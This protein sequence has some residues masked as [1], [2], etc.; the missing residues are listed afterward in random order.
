MAAAFKYIGPKIKSLFPIVEIDGDEMARVIW[1]LVKSNLLS[2]FLSLNIQYFD[3]SI[4]SRD[5][6]ND[7]ITIDAAQAIKKSK[8]GVKCATI[9]PDEY[10]VKEFKLKKMW[11]SPNGTIRNILNGTIFREPI[12]CSNIP[13][14]IPGWK[15][16]IIIA[17]HSYADQYKAVDMVV[18]GPGKL[19]LNYTGMGTKEVFEFKKG[20]RGVALSMYNTEESIRAFAQACFR[21]SLMKKMPLF[22]STKNT[23]LKK[24]DGFFKDIFEEI[25]SKEYK[26]RFKASG[27]AYEHRLI[28]DMVAQMIKSEGGFVWGLKNYDGDVQSDVVAQGFGSLGMMTSVLLAENDVVETEAAH[29]TV[30]RH[31]RNYQK[32]IETSTNSIAIIFAW[33][34]G[35]SH[36]GGMEGNK[37]LVEFAKVLEETVVECVENGI[38]TKDLAISRL[39]KTDVDRKEYQNTEEFIGSVRKALE[40]KIKIQK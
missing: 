31:F 3:L 29:G 39:G 27:I 25:Y 35:L 32:G 21:Y 30:T 40:K 22:F 5:S 23:V 1:S 7:Q 34:K 18:E 15:K 16:P 24:Y 33:T 20:Q 36:L 26:E 6:T 11:V 28:D 4:T 17:R 8:I 10:R 12:V 13:R 19:E 37:Q 9:T 2:P 38:M 14:L